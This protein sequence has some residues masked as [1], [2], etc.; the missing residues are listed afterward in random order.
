MTIPVE[1][2]VG[3][4]PLQSVV[5]QYYQM[6]SAAQPSAPPEVAMREFTKLKKYI[7]MELSILDD[8]QDHLQIQYTTLLYILLLQSL[9][10]F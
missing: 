3:T 9:N 1:I 7:F 5:Q 2:I 10:R 6:L 4:T 8:Q